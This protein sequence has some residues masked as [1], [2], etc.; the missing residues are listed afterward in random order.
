MSSEKTIYCMILMLVLTPACS[1]P[2]KTNQP[3]IVYIMTDQQAFDAM[4]CAGNPLV[5]TPALDR[6]ASDGIRFEQAYCA[7]PLCVPS[8]AAMFSGRM[9]HE[10][11]I[12][13]N[14]R[15]VKDEE[16]PFVCAY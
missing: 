1:R 4:S 8:R 10:A 5:H 3:N 14:T 12:F 2:D 16:F 15:V 7:Y 11:G 6:L 9:P 13:V